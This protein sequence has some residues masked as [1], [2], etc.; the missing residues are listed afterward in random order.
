[1]VVFVSN[2]FNHHQEPLSNSLHEL[3][4]GQ[5]RFIT[6]GQ[7]S[8]ER[9]KLGYGTEEKAYVLDYNREEN[10]EDCLD[11]INNADVVIF[12][13]APEGLFRNRLTAGKLTFM[14]FER[15][16]RNRKKYLVIPKR[17]IDFYRRFGRYKNLYLLCA[18]A[19]TARDFALTGTFIGKAYKFG[20]FP[21]TDH[22]EEP[23][24]LFVKKKGEV[25]RF[26][27]VARFIPLKHPE[28]AVRLAEKLKNKGY[29]FVLDMIGIGEMQEEIQALIR[30]K[31][32][33]DCVHLLGSMKPEEVR[34]HMDK[35]NIFLFTSD[36]AE[37]WGAVLNEAMNSGCAVCAD[38]IIGAAPYLVKDGENGTLYRTEAE[39]YE[40]A[41]TLLKDLALCEAYGR[42]A[43][44]TITEVWNARVAAERL[45]GLAE[46]L[47]SK[48]KADLY[49]DGPLSKA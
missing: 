14:Y 33:T 25:P 48:K 29:S 11:L 19:Y 34:R 30:E 5:Y 16:Y 26:L 2:Y 15:L 24:E 12:G 13:S 8:E 20:Y 32:L 3:T 46:V 43:Y 4:K 36:K 21:K 10:R 39:F 17:L 47:A 37:G 23:D 31:G 28:Y 40:K 27:W 22:Y 45:L 6:T 42:E 35:A 49:E 9:R 41:E 44:R 7:M 1:M 18:S 38:R